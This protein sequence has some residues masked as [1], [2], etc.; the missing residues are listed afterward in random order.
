MWDG[1]SQIDVEPLFWDSQ[2]WW[3]VGNAV[4]SLQQDTS[5]IC[6]NVRN[7]KSS[8]INCW[9][10]LNL[11]YAF[12]RPADAKG[13][14]VA[15]K[16]TLVSPRSCDISLAHPLFGTFSFSS[17]CLQLVEIKE[18]E[19]YY[20]G[21]LLRH[22]LIALANRGLWH[23]DTIRDWWWVGDFHAARCVP[24][25][26]EITERTEIGRKFREYRLGC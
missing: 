25:F 6:Q 18:M 15:T 20:L 8:W 21:F 26:I 10:V 19:Y 22:T 12:L 1:V 2:V 3:T 13:A 9:K 7:C 11:K 24:T 14:S 5:C 17:S 23:V 4:Y 16:E